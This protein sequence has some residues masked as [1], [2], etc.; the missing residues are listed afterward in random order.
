MK[1]HSPA[2]ARTIGI[3]LSG[4]FLVL[5]FALSQP[6][7]AQEEPLPF[8]PFEVGLTYNYI[9]AGDE[10]RVNNLHGGSG[11]IFFN[12]NRWLALGGDFMADYGN[13]SLR[14]SGEG[15]NVDLDRFVYMAGPRLSFWPRPRLRIFAEGMFGGA[16][17]DEH[18]TIRF[19]RNL[20]V[21]SERSDDG[22]AFDFDV[23]TDWRLTE[24]LSWR[25]IQVGYLGTG[26]SLRN[27]DDWQSN[28]RVST[29][30]VLSFGG[31]ESREVRQTTTVTTAK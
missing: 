26:F 11:D 10:D 25:V 29:G 2:Y 30:I 20:L 17:E 6:A 18:T 22:F 8:D 31:R 9:H 13:R 12:V 7:A 4:L 24:R 1:N 3:G 15:A 16:H 27:G 14:I 19:P 21:N 28:L 23:G 5:T